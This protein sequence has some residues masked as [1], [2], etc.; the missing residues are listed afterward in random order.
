MIS[1][2]PDGQKVM[3]WQNKKTPETR[4]LLHSRTPC[5]EVELSNTRVAHFSSRT[6]LLKV[7]THFNLFE[8]I[9]QKS[10]VFKMAE[11]RGFEPPI[12]LRV[13]S[14]SRGAHSTTLPLL[15]ADESIKN[16]VRDASK[17][18]NYESPPG[19]S[20]KTASNRLITWLIVSSGSE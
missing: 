15:R 13:Y 6:S 12:P 10:D 3:K 2:C 9:R 16:K 14:L 1:P 17:T 11:K 20:S 8:K 4:I 18:K 19:I 7:Q 5:S